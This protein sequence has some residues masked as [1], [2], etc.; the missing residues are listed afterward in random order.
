MHREQQAEASRRQLWDLD[1]KATGGAGMLCP[2]ALTQELK[3][4]RGPCCSLTNEG[5][6]LP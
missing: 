2:K 4:S 3:V 1:A 5:T 6:L